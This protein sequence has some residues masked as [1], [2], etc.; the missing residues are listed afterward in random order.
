M[1]KL[2][3]LVTMCTCAYP[4]RWFQV[5]GNLLLKRK[6]YEDNALVFSVGAVTTRPPS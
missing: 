6:G 5:Q 4:S 2:P 3:S 1:V